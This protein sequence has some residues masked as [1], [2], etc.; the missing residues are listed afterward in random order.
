M[1]KITKNT[2][3]SRVK[4]F[5]AAFVFLCVILL[6]VLLM[7]S[8]ESSTGLTDVQMQKS[9]Q[10]GASGTTDVTRNAQMADRAAIANNLNESTASASQEQSGGS[11]SESTARQ[12]RPSSVR[13]RFI[14][15]C[16]KTQGTYCILLPQDPLIASLVKNPL[17]T[18][19]IINGQEVMVERITHQLTH[20]ALPEEQ[21]LS[22]Q[23]VVISSSEKAYDAETLTLNI[24]VS[25]NKSYY[26]SLGESEKQSLYAAQL[27]RSLFTVVGEKAENYAKVGTVVGSLGIWNPQ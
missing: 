12:Q 16:M 7:Q 6:I 17:S 18:A 21:I 11:A 8:R 24:G 13:P 9:G 20:E 23:G 15:P 22:A 4:I 14:V 19:V 5:A 2:S 26:E 3:N 27:L 10:G 25:L 1:K